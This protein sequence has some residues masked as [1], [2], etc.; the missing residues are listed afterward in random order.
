MSC[1]TPVIALQTD[2]SIQ[3]IKNERNGFFISGENTLQ[4]IKLL[5]KN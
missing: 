1:G 4:Q 3:Q 2:G 5:K